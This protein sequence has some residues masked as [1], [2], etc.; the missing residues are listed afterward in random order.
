M[1]SRIDPTAD[2][3]VI[4]AGPTGL[5]LA[6]DL[7]AAGVRVVLLERRARESNLTRAFA[8]HARTLEMLD[9]RSVAEELLATGVFISSARLFGKARLDLS[10][11]PSRFPGVLMTPQY[12][13]ERVLE[14]RAVKLGAEIRRGAE[15]VG[16]RQDADGV[17]VDVRT[18]TAGEPS[19]D[20]P[21][22]GGTTTLRARYVVGADGVH[23]T[24]RQ[25][26]GIPF[27][28]KSVLRSVMLADVRLAA[29]PRETPAFNSVAEGFSLVLPFGDGW[30]RIIAWERGSDLP[31][32]APVE[33]DD[34]R[35]VTRAAFG[36]DFGAH[37][38][39]WTSRFH[40]DERQVPR[41]RDGRVFLAGD[42]AH[43]HSP[44]GG[45]GMNAGMQDAANLGWKLA[46]VLAGRADDALL[47]TYQDERHPVGALVLRLSG[48]ILRMALTGSTVVRGLRRGAAVVIQHVPRVT[49]RPALLVSGLGIRYPAPPGAHPLTGTRAPDLP[50]VEVPDGP[51]RLYEALR[52]GRYV[53]VLPRG[54][55]P[56]DPV[57]EREPDVITVRRTDA[58]Q[59]SL[60][61]RP[62][63]YVAWASDDG[64]TGAVPMPTVGAVPLSRV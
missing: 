42:A 4:G 58:R 43:V 32:D 1:T 61:V 24:V 55:A 52:A 38:A 9:A 31:A 13:T 29:P 48:A 45:M 2:V 63:G 8:V 36:T 57:G 23:S 27:P 33:L 56:R 5:L 50:L 12:E 16:L 47:D 39:R 21:D 30:Y 15:V 49:R 6:G 26:L 54:A 18:H 17:D 28:G 34:L 35:A 59:E 3:L 51:T 14:A 64:A 40:S 62:D 46:A 19:G 10:G 7:A 44:A 25:T 11:L 20:A 37:D 60:L 41:Y 22:D 53:R